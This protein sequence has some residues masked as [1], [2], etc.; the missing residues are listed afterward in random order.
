MFRGNDIAFHWAE[1]GHDIHVVSG[2]PN[3]PSGKF[4][5]GYGLFRKQREVINGVKVTRLPIIP[6]GN[7]K[8][9]L[10]MNYFSYLIVAWMFVF[11]MHSFTNMTESLFNSC[12]IV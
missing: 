9:M 8:I 11:F 7:N 12:V 2:I 10:M 5:D 3:Y 6:R 1:K 4:Y